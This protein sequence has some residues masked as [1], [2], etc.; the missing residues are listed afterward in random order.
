MRPFPGQATRLPCLLSSRKTCR[1]FT[2]LEI[3]VVMAIMVSLIGLAVVKLDDNG[4]RV[5]RKQAE[6]LAI[7]LEAARDEAVYAGQPLAFS[8][9]GLGYK[10]WRGDTARQQWFAISGSDDIAPRT[11]VRNV[12]IIRQIVSGQE[13][14]LGDRLV[15]NA[16]G[17]ADPF[18][19]VLEGGDF[20]IGVE[21]DA[22]GR[23]SLKEKPLEP[24]Q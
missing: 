12:R 4:E 8:S 10:F 18:L 6:E 23:V 14:P 13:R 15:F 22:L 3:L 5:T 16:D 7:R 19:L 2:L 17:L 21:G 1:G 24:Q 11:F 20:R 9:D